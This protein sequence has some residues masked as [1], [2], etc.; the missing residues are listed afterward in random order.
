[1]VFVKCGAKTVF[2]VP[3]SLTSMR[4]A[5]VRRSAGSSILTSS[6]LRHRACFAKPSQVRNHCT[7]FAGVAQGRSAAGL[8]SGPNRNKLTSLFAV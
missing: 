8:M 5:F 6:G 1:L 3:A 4:P 7:A 2:S